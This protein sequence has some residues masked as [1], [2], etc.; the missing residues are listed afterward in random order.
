MKQKLLGLLRWKLKREIDSIDYIEVSKYLKVDNRIAEEMLYEMFKD[1]YL[2]L[3]IDTLCNECKTYFSASLTN[4]DSI[5]CTEC[6]YV[7]SLAEY[8]MGLNYSYTINSN[9]IE[10]D[11]EEKQI[12]VPFK[13]LIKIETEEGKITMSKKIKVFVSYSHK[14]EKYKDKFNTF[15]VMLRRNNVIVAWDDRKLI[16]GDPLDTVID[17]KLEEADLI[18]LL[19][20]Q[21]FLASDYCYTNEMKKALVRYEQ[22]KNII[23]PVILRNCDWLSSPLK[24]IMALPKDG[25]CI[26]SWRDEDEA[27]MDVV[28]GIKKVISK[29][30]GT[31]ML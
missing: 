16:A 9:L 8:N 19:L 7:Q 20:S 26:S 12:V 17:K 28:D 18:I 29:I 23:I 15:I 31:L 10:E 30:T 4:T 25:K 6:G 24:K 14:D 2:N 21:D 13:K 3:R 27:F 22:G 11:I 5:T 1:H